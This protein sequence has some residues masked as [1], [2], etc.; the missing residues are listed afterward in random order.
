[1]L[2]LGKEGMK[3]IDLIRVMWPI[4]GHDLFLERELWKQTTLRY[5]RWSYLIFEQNSSMDDGSFGYP[6]PIQ[7]GGQSEWNVCGNFWSWN[8]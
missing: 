3:W 6:N 2:T 5:S 7:K 4:L 1:M 8:L